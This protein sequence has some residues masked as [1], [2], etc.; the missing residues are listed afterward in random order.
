MVKEKLEEIRQKAIASIEEANDADSLNDIRV[1]LSSSV[2]QEQ[3]RLLFPL[4]LRDSSSV[5]TSTAGMTTVCS[6]SREAAI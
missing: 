2:F 6:T 1:H 5:M 3:E 4:T